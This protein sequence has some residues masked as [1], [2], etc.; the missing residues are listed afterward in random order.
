MHRLFQQCGAMRKLALCAALL[1]VAVAG[2]RAQK[3]ETG[4]DKSADFSRYKTYALVPRATPAT[5][6][7]LA[8]IVD[9]DIIYELEQKGLRRVESNPDLLVKSY[10]GA[11][12]V[13]GGYAAVDPTYNATGGA[14]M[15]GSTMWTGSLP[16]ATQ[17]QVMK[18]FITID[19]LDARQNQL[20]WRATAKGKIDYN[21]RQ[22]M[23]EKAN[24]AV[25][26]MFKKFPPEK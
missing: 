16:P 3:I 5:N 20:V 21:K 23:L 6:P 1:L 17:P 25:A 22:K 9:H 26:E 24:K 13:E 18:G 11:G 14:P 15:A 7:L 10:G 2:A 8:A 4:Y 19:L 12:E